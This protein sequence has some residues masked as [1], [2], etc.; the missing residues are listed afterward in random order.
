MFYTIYQFDPQAAADQVQLS[1]SVPNA[2]SASTRKASVF[3]LSESVTITELVKDSTKNS[4]HEMTKADVKLES[5]EQ[6]QVTSASD[7]EV[8]PSAA[9][10]DPQH[11]RVTTEQTTERST[12]SVT[13]KVEDINTQTMENSAPVEKMVV[14]N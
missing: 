1:P 11:T 6:K 8:G 4:P 2:T 13:S 10:R 7:M 5:G 3:E 14:S 9:A 12:N